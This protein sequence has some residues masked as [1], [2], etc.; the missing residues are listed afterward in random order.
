MSIRKMI[1]YRTVWMG[2]AMLWIMLYHSGLKL[3]GILEGIRSCGYGGVDVFIFASGVGNYYSYTRDENPLR[4]LKRRLLKL[5]PAYLVFIISWCLVHVLSGRMSIV[6]VP[7]N[8]FGLQGFSAAGNFNW[9]ITGILICYLLTP[10]LASCVRKNSP[11][12]CLLLTAALVIVSAA[13]VNDGDLIIMVTRLPVYVAGM[14]F[15][16]YDGKNVKEIRLPLF[17]MFAAGIAA[18]TLV[19]IYAEKYLWNYGLHW[20]PFLLIV[21]FLCLAISQISDFWERHGLGIINR[22]FEKTGGISFEIYL[23]HIFVFQEFQRFFSGSAFD[24]G[25]MWCLVILF[26]LLCAWLYSIMIRK[27]IGLAQGKQAKA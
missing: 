25:G 7:R 3:P 18:L 27:M 21:P 16:K 23:L 22:F 24:S 14:I 8:L 19:R 12:K 10:Y 5:A 20:Y 15:A 9:F 2:A 11:G 26:S 13:F 4:F 17:L 1:S 6:N